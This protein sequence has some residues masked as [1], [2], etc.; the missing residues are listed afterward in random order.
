M[1]T[2]PA[3]VTPGRQINRLLAFKNPQS[4]SPTL[5]LSIFCV[6]IFV[7]L[8]LCVHVP[9]CFFFFFFT[10]YGCLS[11]SNTSA[12]TLMKMLRGELDSHSET[13]SMQLEHSPI[14]SHRIV[15]FAQ[16][17]EGWSKKSLRTSAETNTPLSLI[18][19]TGAPSVKSVGRLN[20]TS[21]SLPDNTQTS[22]EKSVLSKNSKSFLDGYRGTKPLIGE[23]K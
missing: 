22:H 8:F 9:F 20:N 13:T 17:Q 2:V 21:T 6:Y 14:Q 11:L 12:V 3:S 15:F 1:S 18:H 23:H 10:P 7:V 5:G 16:N 19:S 4:F